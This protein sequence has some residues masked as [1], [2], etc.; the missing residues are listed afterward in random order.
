MKRDIFGKDLVHYLYPEVDEKP[1]NLPTQTPTIYIFNEKPNSTDA[2]AGTGATA[3]IVTWTAQDVT[4]FAR[5]WTVPAI[6]D[7]DTGSSNSYE[8]YW[9]AINFRYQSSEQIQTIIRSFNI[10]RGEATAERP[11]VSVQD[12]RNVYPA[13]NKYC[14]ESELDEFLTFALDTVRLD[15]KNKGLD[16]YR[17]RNHEELKLPL[18]YKT[19]AMASLSQVRTPGDRFELRYTEFNKLYGEA[20]TAIKLPYDN[21]GDG[22][23]DGEIP[24]GTSHWIVDR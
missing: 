11:D 21:D 19:I 8:T 16:W 12:L 9:E 3:G 7:P 13:I 4:P 24:A 18:V 2:A 6:D 5:V 23:P 10:Y 15:L 17:L 1:F 22:E 20:L 14:S